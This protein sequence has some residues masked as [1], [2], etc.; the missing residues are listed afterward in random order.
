MKYKNIKG[1]WG[2]RKTIR[3][4]K[5]EP[6]GEAV[7]EF[8]KDWAEAMEKEI[9]KGRKIEDCAKECLRKVDK[10]ITGFMYGCAVGLL[11]CVWEHG[12]SLRIWHNLDTQI[13]DEGE[14]ANKN[15]GVLNPAL[16]CIKEKT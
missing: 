9:K 10:G 7:N 12:E 4:N 3:A 14:R 16:L 15:G 11:S 1:W 6:Y 2:W 13:G 8:A 5:G